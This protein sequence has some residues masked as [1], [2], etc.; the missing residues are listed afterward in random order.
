MGRGIC[1]C[2]IATRCTTD[3]SGKG[4][5]LEVRD[6]RLYSLLLQELTFPNRC[7]KERIFL[8]KFRAI[9]TGKSKANWRG[10]MA[11]MAEASW[12][13][14]LRL[15]GQY[16]SKIFPLNLLFASVFQQSFWYRI[17]QRCSTANRD[18]FIIPMYYHRFDHRFDR[19]FD[20]RENRGQSTVATPSMMS[21]AET[22]AHLLWK[23]NRGN[24]KRF[25]TIS[26]TAEEAPK[27]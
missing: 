17:V 24:L 5:R 26:G 22:F 21:S 12:P 2:C 10:F 27:F 4:G 11:N 9:I 14:W 7:T 18:E 19:R 3:P 16:G 25:R 15:H 6:K 20:R 23:S 1:V 8:H 13:I